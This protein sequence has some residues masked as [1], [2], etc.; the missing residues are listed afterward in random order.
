M[1]E[2]KDIE[3]YAKLARIELSH[4]EI[5]KFPKEIESILGYINQIK[6]V[7]GDVEIKKAGDHRNI[8]RSDEILHKS[9]EYTDAIVR[10]MP[11]KKDNYLEVKKIIG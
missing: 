9:G 11:K 4:E 5:E 8:V 1:I 6:E 2:P 7:S 10:N 3:K